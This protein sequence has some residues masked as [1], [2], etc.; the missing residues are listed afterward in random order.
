MYWRDEA[1]G[2]L[3]GCEFIGTEKIKKTFGKGKER[4]FGAV[5][6][7]FQRPEPVL[8]DTWRKFWALKAP[9]ALPL[10]NY[11]RALFSC[12]VDVG[13]LRDTRS[14]ENDIV[15][16]AGVNHCRLC[17]VLL[18]G[19][20]WRKSRTYVKAGQCVSEKKWERRTQKKSRP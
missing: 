5:K 15:L 1:C 10:D 6:R 20:G 19:D 17:E 18:E 4:D 11:V 8:H 14:L 3:K 13:F 16:L 2:G 9:R 12:L 7:L